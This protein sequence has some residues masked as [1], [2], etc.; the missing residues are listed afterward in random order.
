MTVQ[1]INVSKAVQDF[2]GKAKEAFD[3][4]N[5]DY[6][7]TILKN[8]LRTNPDYYKARGLLRITQLKQAESVKTNALQKE[9][10]RVKLVPLLLK[11]LFL[12]F[13]KKWPQNIEALEEALK[14]D[15]TNTFAL[16][17]LAHS[18]FQLGWTQTAVDTLE[19]LKKISPN[20]FKVLLDLGQIYMSAGD[21]EKSRKYFQEA[22][23]LSPNNPIAA[24]GLKDFAAMKTIEQ[25]GWSDTNSSYRGKIKDEAQAEM[26]EKETKAVKSEE[27]L[28]SLIRNVEQKLKEQSDNPALLKELAEL[29]A[30]SKNLDAAIETYQKLSSIISFDENIQKQITQLSIQKI[31]LESLRL[32][33]MLSKNPDDTALKTE[34]N[35][36][37]KK[38]NE[39][40]MTEAKSRVDRFPNNL[41][42]RYELGYLYFEL[43]KYNEAIQEF[44][45]SA[46]DPQK[47]TRSLY[48]LGLCF[49]ASGFYDLAEKQ[50]LKV[51]DELIDMDNFK[52]EVI[53]NLGLVYEAMGHVDKAVIEY[54]KIFEVDIGFKDI[55]EKIQKAYKK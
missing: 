23:R 33:E 6:A 29:Q 27:D 1:E 28:S 51:V 4:N 14:I 18:A 35:L 40:L 11:I 10:G 17:K 20:N 32:H 41:N 8:I 19:I 12:S 42:Y 15:P 16:Q 9:L 21:L 53:Y 34:L 2:Y 37:E 45:N 47:K 54:K 22:S 50:F 39:M 5:F 13:K 48:Y 30:Q 36:L 52:K 38:K 49:K 3:R 24:K 31:N 25:G 26:F 55:T 46:R 43:G 44:Q 7:Q